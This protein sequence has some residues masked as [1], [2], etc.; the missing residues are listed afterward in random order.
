MDLWRIDCLLGK[1]LETNNETIAVATQ[2][3]GKHPST[4]IEL[5]LQTLLCTPL[6]GSCNSWTTTME[7]GYFLC[8]PRRGVILKAIVAKQL[9]GLNLAMVK[10]T[11][12]QKT[13][14]PL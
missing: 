10:L 12:V 8:C 6:Q 11:T 9:R 3:G 13:K 14:L 4:A 2:R 1:D 7:T 5:L